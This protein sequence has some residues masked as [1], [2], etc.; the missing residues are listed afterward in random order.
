MRAPLRTAALRVLVPAALVVAVAVPGP[1][2]RAGTTSI[3]DTCLV[4]SWVDQSYTVTI[5]WNGTQISLRGGT[6]AVEQIAANGTDI[7]DYTDAAPLVGPY[8]GSTLK[9]H[10]GGSVTNQL[11]ADPTNQLLTIQGISNDL[12]VQYQYKGK[13]YNG[14]LTLPDQS[15]SV[16]YTC[17]QTTL[18]TV[19]G[20]FNAMRLTP[21]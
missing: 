3:G 5:N 8:A 2:A 19:G 14:F 11:S 10:L 18:S 4:G 9:A 1:P 13:L 16:P 21:G 20:L 17:N 6:G 7:T 12:A 15:Y